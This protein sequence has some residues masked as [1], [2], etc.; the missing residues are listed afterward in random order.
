MGKNSLKKEKKTKNAHT[1]PKY[2][3]SNESLVKRKKKHRQ[4][5][6]S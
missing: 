2:A 1:V 5:S 6:L 4:N 3:T